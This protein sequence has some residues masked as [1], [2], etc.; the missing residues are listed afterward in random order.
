MD[1]KE[2]FLQLRKGNITA[3]ARA[4]T[5]VESKLQTDRILA[6]E[7][8][9]MCLPFTGNSF[10]M[11]ITGVPGVGKSSFI[12]SFGLHLIENKKKLAVLAIDPS[13]EKSGGSILGDK[14]RMEKLSS[15]KNV[16]IRPTPSGGHLGGVARNT[17][18]AV[19]LC[20][21]AGFDFIIIETVGVGQS[22]T[23]VKHLTDFF[24]LLMLAG[25]GDE[26]Q[27]IKRGIM[28]M[29]DS[30]LINKADGN[31]LQNCKIAKS[32]FS[33]AI[34]YLPPNENGWIPNVDICSA[35]TGLGIESFYD[36]IISFEAQQKS[37]G[38]FNKTRDAQKLFWFE[39]F[40]VSEI[41]KLIETSSKLKYSFDEIKMNLITNNL[42][43][44]SAVK[45]ILS[46]IAESLK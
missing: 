3:L 13:S 31:N 29:A 1:I 42:S 45:T 16:F 7:L 22:E 36:K 28:E 10:R 25:S 19:I 6:D 27:G 21:A 20:E 40:L 23:I 18:E 38:Y 11:G 8:I 26:L 32:E 14:T 15:G 41:K 4:I 17:Y 9:D 44:H 12:E 35:V 43:P 46:R 33:M 5:L 30:I 37:S 39:N 24:L 34:H 2:L